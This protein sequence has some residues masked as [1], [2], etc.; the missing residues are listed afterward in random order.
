MERAMERHITDDIY[1][2]PMNGA[3]MPPRSGHCRQSL[4]MGSRLHSWRNAYEAWTEV[5]QRLKVIVKVV[6]ERF[7]KDV[8]ATTTALLT[9][10]AEPSCRRRYRFRR[11]MKAGT[12]I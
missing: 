7:Q 11:C 8:R 1:V 2:V 12:N 3:A 4:K 9:D 10:I 5:A 6:L